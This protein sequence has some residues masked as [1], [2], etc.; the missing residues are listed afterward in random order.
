MSERP[1]AKSF[2]RIAKTYPPGDDEYLTARQR[3]GDP[4]PHSNDAVKRSWDGLS[5]YDSE[6]GAREKA[7]R[8]KGRLGALIVRYEI[9]EGAGIAWEPSFGGGNHDLFGD[10]AEFKGYLSDDVVAV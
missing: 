2:F 5:A 9:P 1:I 4:A 10:V 3:Y 8:L 7:K 6:D